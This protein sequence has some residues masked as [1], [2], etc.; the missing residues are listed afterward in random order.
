MT[1]RRT[2][3]CTSGT[4]S[5]STLVRRRWPRTTR[6]RAWTFSWSRWCPTRSRTMGR[7]GGDG[8]DVGAELGVEAGDAEARSVLAAGAGA[9]GRAARD[10][11][12]QRFDIELFEESA[13]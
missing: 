1:L 4:C 8:R 6:S 2:T 10:G 7:S 5:V 3:S 12:K 9:L 13:R 11:A